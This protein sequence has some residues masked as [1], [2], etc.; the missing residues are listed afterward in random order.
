VTQAKLDKQNGQPK[1]NRQNGIFQTGQAEQDSQN[2]IGHRLTEQGQAEQDREN[3]ADGTGQ[4][5][6]EKHAK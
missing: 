5:E 6:Q 1:Q 3:S 4:A 2:R